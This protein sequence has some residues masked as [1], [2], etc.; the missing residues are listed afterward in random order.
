MICGSAGSRDP[1]PLL[2]C[3]IIFPVI[4][5]TTEGKALVAFLSQDAGHIAAACHMRLVVSMEM[6]LP[7]GSHK[8]ARDGA[9]RR[10]SL[11]A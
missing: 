5:K 1:P 2:W 8:H 9:Q 4:L 11:T 7:L 3:L 10:L 6:K